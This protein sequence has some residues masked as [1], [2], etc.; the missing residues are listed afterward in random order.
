[1]NRS[2][3][4]PA[5]DAPPPDVVAFGT[6]QLDLF[7]VRPVV[8]RL[9]PRRVV[10]PNTGVEAIVR[11][12]LRPNAPTHLVF[13]D[14]HGWYCEAHGAECAAVAMARDD[15]QAATDARA[16]RPDAALPDLF[17]NGSA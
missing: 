17:A 13:H 12:R 14:R 15:A 8:E 16:L 7:P 5:A 9:D 11:V 10:G 6:P 3:R 1:M 2:R 4:H